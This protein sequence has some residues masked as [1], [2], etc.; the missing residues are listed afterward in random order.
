MY[1]GNIIIKVYIIS[2]LKCSCMN[3]CVSL[4]SVKIFRKTVKS[5][6]IM[7]TVQHLLLVCNVQSFVDSIITGF[8]CKQ[9]GNYTKNIDNTL[10]R[11]FRW[12]NIKIIFKSI[13]G[14]LEVQIGMRSQ[15]TAAKPYSK[16]YMM[17]STGTCTLLFFIASFRFDA[18][19]QLVF[20]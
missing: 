17:C 19:F 20:D 10:C 16:R 11:K 12:K 4:L 13:Y 15:K 14:F 6:A 3:M 2:Q 5:W 7:K 1:L 9:R 18:R 8:F